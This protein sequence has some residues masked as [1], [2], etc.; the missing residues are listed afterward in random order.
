MNCQRPNILWSLTQG[1]QA[2][3]NHV[4]PVKQIAPEGAVCHVLRQVAVGRG[5]HAHRHLE[6]AFAAQP[7]N[8]ALLQRAQQLGLQGQRHLANLIEKNRPLIGLLK[9]ACTRRLRAGESA[10]LVAKQFRLE[11]RVGNRR[12]V[13]L[14]KR[15]VAPLAGQ[16][17]GA[18][19][20]LF[21]RTGL[22][23]QQHTGRGL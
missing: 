23:Q 20:Q 2:N 7:H 10:A 9:P 6:L 22:A 5:H 15:L 11:Q 14:D 8:G 16:M 18:C 3:R 13:H 1:G 4:E 19:K 17:H 12:A 21:A